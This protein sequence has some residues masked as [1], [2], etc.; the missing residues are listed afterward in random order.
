MTLHIARRLRENSSA[1]SN[2]REVWR[3]FLNFP[4]V[5]GSFVTVIDDVGGEYPFLSCADFEVG[6]RLH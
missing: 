1:G 2:I 3:P 4:I 6:A 5:L